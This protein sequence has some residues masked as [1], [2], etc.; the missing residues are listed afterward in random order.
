MK[1]VSRVMLA[2]CVAMAV[3]TVT[4]GCGDNADP[5]E[6]P[7]PPPPPPP[8]PGPCDGELTLEQF[9]ECFNGAY[10]ARVLDCGLGEL[11]DVDPDN[12]GAALIRAGFA[13]QSLADILV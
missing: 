7:E 3:T 13:P 2:C 8:E 1:R 5:I 12:V 4:S 6:E 10:V 9:G 11:G